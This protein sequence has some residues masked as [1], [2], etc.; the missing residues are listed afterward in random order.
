MLAIAGL[1]TGIVAAPAMAHGK[2]NPNAGAEIYVT[3]QDRVYES[4]VLGDLPF[5]GNAKFQKLE[6]GGP[7]G[8]RTEFGRGDREYRG[9]RWWVDVNGNNVM[10]GEDAF[11]LCPLVGPGHELPS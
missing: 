11:F 4:I 1:L 7:T 3:S 10:D 5:V 8:L 9:G 6:M 2:S